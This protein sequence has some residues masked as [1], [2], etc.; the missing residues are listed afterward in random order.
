MPLSAST[1]L[2]SYGTG[3][4]RQITFIGLGRMG[5]AMASHLQRAGHQVCVYNRSPEK[6]TRWAK[7]MGGRMALHLSEAL[8][9]AEIVIS[10]V[11]NDQDMHALTIGSAGGFA[12][13]PTGTAWIDHTTTS[14]TLARSLQ[15][16]AQAQGIGFVDAPVSGGVLGAQNGTLTIMCGGDA[17]QIEAL[18]GVMQAYAQASRRIGPSGSGQL[19][20]MVNQICIAGIV[21]GLAEGLHF[22]L[23]ANLDMPA[24]LDVISQGAAQS[25]QLQ[26]RGASM[27]ANEFD[28]G[29]AVD[30]MRKDLGLALDQARQSGAVLPL[31]AL[32]DQFYAELQSSGAG[33]WDTSS[34]IHRLPRTPA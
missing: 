6:S 24:V 4:R 20:K 15:A 26:H 23:Q 19:A 17:A 9:N 32:V 12:A 34:L 5:Y 8:Q 33:R 2:K 28:F 25:W 3:P 13:L 22:G 16:A 7:E 18:Q 10:C 29:F 27:L 1:S 14:A 31:T 11:G 21:Q 30:W